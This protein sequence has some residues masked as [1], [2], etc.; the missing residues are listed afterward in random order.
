MSIA[1]PVFP[2][3][4]LVEP[5]LRAVKHV[6]ETN[7]VR[8]TSMVAILTPDAMLADLKAR[9]SD[10]VISAVKCTGDCPCT[11]SLASPSGLNFIFARDFLDVDDSLL[12]F[13]AE[14]PVY[15]DAVG[16][17]NNM[18]SGTFRNLLS[19]GKL[20]CG[21]TPPVIIDSYQPLVSSVLKA[22]SAIVASFDVEQHVIVV[23]LWT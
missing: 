7:L 1:A 15:R 2:D 3:R 21:L 14:L 8:R 10:I 12:Q 19:K 18:I 16:E 11:I 9:S 17:M 23:S 13:G 6:F 22:K 4:K 20:N 5:L